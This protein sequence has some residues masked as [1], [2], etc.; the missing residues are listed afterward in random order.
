[1]DVQ[2]ADRRD[3]AQVI[4]DHGPFSLTKRKDYAEW[5]AKKLS[6]VAREPADLLVE[7]RNPTAL[8]ELERRALHE[9]VSR[10][11]MAIYRF[12]EPASVDKPTLRRFG[13][14]L[15]LDHLDHNPCADEDHI[16]TL[17]VK[18]LP[19]D[20]IYIPYSNRPLNWHTDGY[21]NP[22][23]QLVRTIVLHCATP[24][25]VGGE[26]GLLDHELVYLQLRDESPEWVAAL[27][28]PNAM[29]IPANLEAGNE[30]RGVQSGPVF[31]VDAATGRL[32]M[33]YTARRRNVLWRDDP[34]TQQAAT[35]LRE[36]TEHNAFTLRYRLQAGEGLISNNTLH[37]RSAFQDD[38]ER[39]RTL[40]RARYYD[41]ITF[42]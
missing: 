7:I 17:C 28:Q 21:Y 4:P 24:A 6:Q 1:M 32:A 33:R 14:S 41:P 10:Y 23:T 2:G 3:Q 39:P 31:L 30:I 16:T 8:S 22:T 5:R 12:A 38:P 37:C 18:N 36:L 27:M 29:C 9:R 15:G 42:S 40:Y 19:G 11:N 35:R 20:K 34:L 26:N 13:H 25:A